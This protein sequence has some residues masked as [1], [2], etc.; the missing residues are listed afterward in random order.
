MDQQQPSE[1]LDAQQKSELQKGYF[2]KD[3]SLKHKIDKAIL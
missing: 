3:I 2:K 1:N